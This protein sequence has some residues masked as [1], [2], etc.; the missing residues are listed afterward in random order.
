MFR[1][2]NGKLSSKRIL[3]ALSVLVALSITISKIW[4]V[5]E[6]S[7]TLILGIL[8]AGFT[9]VAVGTFEKKI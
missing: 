2:I 6:I 8:T 7:D 1:D 5:M 9:A 4:I 3:G